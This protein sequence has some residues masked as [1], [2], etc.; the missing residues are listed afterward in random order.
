MRKIARYGA[1][2]N[3]GV[4]AQARHDLLDVTGPKLPL[5]ARCGAASRCHRTD[6]WCSLLRLEGL[7]GRGSVAEVSTFESLSLANDILFCTLTKRLSDHRRKL[8][9]L[10]VRYPQ[11]VNLNVGSLSRRAFKRFVYFSGSL[12]DCAFPVQS[13]QLDRDK[14]GQTCQPS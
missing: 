9:P 10:N 14:Y 11:K 4:I 8:R 12:P 6:H 1:N 2:T 13:I 7:S 5:V 3:P